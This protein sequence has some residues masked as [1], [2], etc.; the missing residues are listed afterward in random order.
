[1]ATILQK[2]KDTINLAAKIVV[3][4]AFSRDQGVAIYFRQLLKSESQN[5]KQ[6]SALGCG[7]LSDN[8][9]IDDLSQLLQEQSL[10]SIRTASLALAAIG[11]KQSLEILAS[12]L[13]N[14]S[15]LARRYAAEALANNPVEG[16][17]ALQDGSGME[18]VLVRRS[19][20]FGLIRV[21]QPWAR[22]IVENLQ[23]DDNEWVV[24]NAA[25]QAFDELKRKSSY[26]PR[27]LPDLTET[28]WL[29]EYATRIGTTVAP[30]KP[31]EGLIRKA[32]TSGNNDEQL[33]AIEYLRN[34]I[35][36][37]AMDLI[38]TTYK[39]S[40]GELHEAAYYLLWLMTITGIKLPYSF[41]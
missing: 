19:V 29:I 20:V 10:T 23:L 37:K 38:Y 11:D 30:G 12:N 17:P 2:E 25:I 39:N 5:L 9:A 28:Q 6:L 15:E 3:A 31:A 1:L 4:M 33:N 27:H 34:K 22:K 26:A 21:D 14:G 36:P 35:D 32:L 16:Y 7:I 41:E 24:R 40:T 8:K 13:L 18:D